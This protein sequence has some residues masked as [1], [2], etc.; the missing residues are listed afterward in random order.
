M[1]SAS[2]IFLGLLLSVCLT[3]YGSCGMVRAGGGAV[4][5]MELCAGGVAK[6][7]HFDADGNPVEPTAACSECMSCCQAVGYLVPENSSV[8]SSLVIAEMALERLSAQ[9]TIHN[10]R[11]ILP[12]PRGPP[13]MHMSM[14]IKTGLTLVDQPDG[15]QIMRSDGRLLLKDAFA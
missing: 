4:I 8:A 13:T 9:T 6:T 3:L 1:K 5:S 7:V 2:T 15:G 12:A 10:K 11:Q 14:V